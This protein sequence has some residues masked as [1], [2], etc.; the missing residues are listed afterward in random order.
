MPV[1]LIDFT[2]SSTRQFYLSMG[3]PSGVK[4]LR[5]VSDD[6]KM[7][8]KTIIIIGLRLLLDAWLV[9]TIGYE[10]LMPIY[11]CMEV[12]HG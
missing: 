2:L 5:E 12:N 6:F 7:L 9:L 10:L 11:I 4:R 1:T 8:R 3:N